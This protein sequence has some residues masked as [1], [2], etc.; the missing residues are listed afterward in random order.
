ME[1]KNKQG[2]DGHGN[3]YADHKRKDVILAF[4]FFG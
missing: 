4:F 3:K 2:N 1:E